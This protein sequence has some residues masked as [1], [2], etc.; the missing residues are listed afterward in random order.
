[1]VF[2][3]L[4]YFLKALCPLGESDLQAAM[5]IG[6]EQAFH[7]ELFYQLRQM[8]RQQLELPS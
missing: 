2:A 1:M 4:M 7:Q 8:Q 3:V 5:L 6:P